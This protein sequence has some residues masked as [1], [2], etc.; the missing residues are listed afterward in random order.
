MRIVSRTL[1]F[2]LVLALFTAVQL[3]AQNN[4]IGAGATWNQEASPQ[5]AAWGS[6]G[7]CVYHDAAGPCRVLS[8]TTW[9][10]TFTPTEIPATATTPAR[11][12]WKAQYSQRTGAALVAYKPAPNL[13]LIV[14][15]DGGPAET[16]DAIGAAY[17][18]GAGAVW[19]HKSGFTAEFIWRNLKTTNSNNPKDFRFG[20]GWSF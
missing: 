1:A 20:L 11:T 3:P 5:F 17:S 10:I 7:K 6:F 2:A 13:A 4:W 8:L 16:G 19:E 15:A 9:D 14:L 12:Q 18:A